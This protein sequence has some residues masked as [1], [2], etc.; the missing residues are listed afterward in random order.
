MKL[1]DANFSTFEQK[2]EYLYHMLKSVIVG[3]PRLI[4]KEIKKDLK[5]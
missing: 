4:F 3:D 2:D 5:H 1:T